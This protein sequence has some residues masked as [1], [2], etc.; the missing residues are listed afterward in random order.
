MKHFILFCLFISSFEVVGQLGNNFYVTSANGI[1]FNSYADY[2]RN[3]NKSTFRPGFAMGYLSNLN[4]SS[5]QVFPI[6]IGGEFGYQGMGS[7][8]VESQVN[9]IFTNSNSLFWLNG[10]ARYRPNPREERLNSF[11]D[12]AAG[13]RWQS[14]SV[15]QVF[16]EETLR[17]ASQ[18]RGGMNYSFGL[19][20]DI[21]RKEGKFIE[22]GIYWRG[23]PR[24][25]QL[26]PSS[27][28]ID[29]NGNV[30]YA[31][32]LLGINQLEFRLGFLRMN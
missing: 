3:L 27:I 29:S 12:I 7:T 21:A 15:S 17:L 22:L 13:F 30:N 5:S 6:S 24:I 31:F 28:L 14:S 4:K 20:L 23:A 9:G 1:A 26:L 16:S 19:G 8:D 10:V 18:T 25:R 32:G 2:L 11:F